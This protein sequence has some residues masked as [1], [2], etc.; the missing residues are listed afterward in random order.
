MKIGILV[1]SK[2]NN[3]YSVAEKLKKKLQDQGQDVVV[4]RI[5][6]VNDDPGVKSPIAFSDA[7]DVTPYDMVVLGSPVWGFS[8]SLIMKE[9]LE[10]ISSLKGK[11][12][13]CFVTKQLA[14][15][16]TGGNKA[17]RQMSDSVIAKNGNCEGTFII[18]WK[19]K[20]REEEISRLI[21]E[22]SDAV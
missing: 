17:I 11:K 22:I 20:K 19:S 7:P 14:S 3:T 2:T 8:L 10:Q 9:Y 15:K 4:Q 21:D 1:F 12:V 18:S 16:F 6:P 13:Y 5:V